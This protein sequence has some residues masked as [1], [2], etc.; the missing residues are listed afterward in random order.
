MKLKN[1]IRKCKYSE[2]SIYI[3]SELKKKDRAKKA[4]CFHER[5]IIIKAI[6]LV[7]LVELLVF[8]ILNG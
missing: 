2:E 5:K 7:L 3:F 6:V 4:M 1:L 8:I